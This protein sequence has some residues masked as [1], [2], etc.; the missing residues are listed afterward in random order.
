M[1]RRLGK[2]NLSVGHSTVMRLITALGIDFDSQVEEWKKTLIRR[3]QLVMDI[4]VDVYSYVAC[5]AHQ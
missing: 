2:L 3:V 5:C 1:Y 4:Q